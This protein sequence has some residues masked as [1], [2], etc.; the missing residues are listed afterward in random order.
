M[1][2]V[3]WL[4]AA[5][6]LYAYLGY[7]VWLWLRSRWRRKPVQR[8][9]ITPAVSVVMVVRNEETA[10]PITLR[11]LTALDY[12]RDWMEILVVSDGSQDGTER[13]LQ[14]WTQCGDR[15]AVGTIPAF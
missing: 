4:S 15:T 5:L 2:W 12:P 13:I 10:L 1:K 7:P 8:E 11:N 9:S 6:I 3:F 14:D